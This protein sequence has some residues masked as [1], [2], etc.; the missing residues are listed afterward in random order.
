[1]LCDDNEYYINH[2]AEAKKE[3]DK[4]GN[5]IEKPV[6]RGGTPFMDFRNAYPDMQRQLI[7]YGVSRKDGSMFYDLFKYKDAAFF[8]E[9]PVFTFNYEGVDTR[10][11]IYLAGVWNTAEGY[12]LNT[13]FRTDE[14]FAE[15]END[16]IA[17]MATQDIVNLDPAVTIAPG[18]QVMLLGTV[19]YEF[20]G[21][22]MCVWAR[23][24]E[25]ET[26]S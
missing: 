23:R 2:S 25:A 15:Y 21:A 16:V 17:F 14:M 22:Y 24:I 8:K 7:I 10:W 1:M 3:L 13:A 5:V 11:Q 6:S 9:N 20:E 26:G 12:V 4:A 19:S 18:D